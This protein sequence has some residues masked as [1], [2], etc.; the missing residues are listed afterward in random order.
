MM[1]S[2]SSSLLVLVLLAFVGCSSEPPA[3]P[4]PDPEPV[5]FTRLGQ[6]QHADLADT[7]ETI[8]R[9]AASWA[10][11][12]ASLRPMVPFDSV[13]FSTHVV[14]LAAVPVPSGGYNLGFEEVYR[15]GD[16][17]VASYILMQP[18][19]DCATAQALATPFQAIMLPTP[20][21]PIR[22]ERITE[23]YSCER[24]KI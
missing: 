12:S 24:K 14:L 3:P 7:T 9:D 23:A 5:S 8:V 18:G 1:P 13:D 17:I 20:N 6:G 11:L 21:A 15:L 22:L 16:E 2:F 4:P 19:E 10:T